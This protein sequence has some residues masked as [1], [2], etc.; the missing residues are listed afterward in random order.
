MSQSAKSPSVEERTRA[1]FGRHRALVGMIHVGAL[2]GTPRSRF[3]IDVALLPPTSD[4]SRRSSSRGARRY[5]RQGVR[6][7][8]ADGYMLAR[9]ARATSKQSF[10]L[11]SVSG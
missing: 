7:A 3:S 4:L 10:K 1:L 8:D 11:P 5:W 2:P 9:T 6:R